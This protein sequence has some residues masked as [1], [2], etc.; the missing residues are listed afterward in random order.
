MLLRAADVGACLRLVGEVGVS[1]SDAPTRRARVLSGLASIVEADVWTWTLQRLDGE[2]PAHLPVIE[3]GWVDAAQKVAWLRGAHAL[4]SRLLLGRLAPHLDR[5]CTFVR[6]DLLDDAAWYASEYYRKYREPA[7]LDDLLLSLF[8]AGPGVQS[9]LRLQRF[10]GRPCFDARERDLVHLVTE[11]VEWL[12]RPDLPEGGFPALDGL[13]PRAQQ[14]L[15][16]LLQGQGKQQ[17]AQQLCLSRHTVSDYL[18]VLHRH[19]GVHT[20]AELLARFIRD[21]A[22]PR[23]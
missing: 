13:T 10:Q 9:A 11:A 6:R 14:V 4:E 1:A 22:P 7:G 2:A 18:K 12:H 23:P 3:G 8:P 15:Y 20:R 17:I 5:H 16:L 19:F 21:A